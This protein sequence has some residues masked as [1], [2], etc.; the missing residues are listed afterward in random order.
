MT[1]CMRA[2]TSVRRIRQS[3]EQDT[4]LTLHTTIPPC[5]TLGGV[6]HEEVS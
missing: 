4:V 5:G 6:V 3:L 2:R 1:S